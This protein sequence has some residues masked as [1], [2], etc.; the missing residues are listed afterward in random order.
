MTYA[1]MF[2]L[3]NANDNFTTIV[4]IIIAL[5]FNISFYL[6]AAIYFIK[7]YQH[8]AKKLIKKVSFKISRSLSRIESRNNIDHEYSVSSPKK[9]LSIT[10]KRSIRYLFKSMRIEVTEPISPKANTDPSSIPSEDEIEHYDRKTVYAERKEQPNYPIMKNSGYHNSQLSHRLTYTLSV[11][12]IGSPLFRSSDA[13]LLSPGGVNARLI[14]AENPL[15]T[16]DIAETHQDDNLDTLQP[17]SQHRLRSE[18]DD[19]PTL[20]T[21]QSDLQIAEL[22]SIH[23]DSR[24]TEAEEK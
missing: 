11:S 5:I 2:F 16:L 19:Y 14:N 1:G 21:R 7:S 4:F 12:P 20:A 6:I 13:E 18:Y 8:A 15:R 23:S 24:R 3:S 9:D 17:N 10:N 22:R